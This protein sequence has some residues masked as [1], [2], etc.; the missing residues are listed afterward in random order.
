MVTVIPK[1]ITLGM[2]TSPPLLCLRDRKK[3]ENSSETNGRGNIGVYKKVR[4]RE[5]KEDKVAIKKQNEPSLI[6]EYK[7]KQYF[8]LL[9]SFPSLQNHV[10]FVCVCVCVCVWTFIT[11]LITRVPSL[12]LL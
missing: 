6:V 9:F 12:E 11:S 10:A 4:R 7:Q 1:P 2:T 5:V 3:R 8:F